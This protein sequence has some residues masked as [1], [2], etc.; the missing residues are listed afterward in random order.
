MLNFGTDD[1]RRIYTLDVSGHLI[2]EELDY[3]NDGIVDKTTSYTVD[4]RGYVTD[5]YIDYTSDGTNDRHIVYTRDVNGKVIKQETDYTNDGSIEQV[6]TYELDALGQQEV[7]YFDNNN[8]GSVDRT[9]Y[10]TRDANGYI[11]KT[12]YDTDGDQIID[13]HTKYVNDA[14]GRV[15]KKNSDADNTGKNISSETYTLNA[16]GFKAVIEM[17]TDGDSA[18]DKTDVN[19]FDSFGNLIKIERDLTNNGLT[20]DDTTIEYTYNTQGYRSSVLIT[21]SLTKTVIAKEEYAYSKDS[22]L[23]KEA[24]IDN[25]ND[26]LYTN[27]LDRRIVKTYDDTWQLIETETTYNGL[28]TLLNT[29]VYER[30]NV[31]IPIRTYRDVNNDGSVQILFYGDAQG[32]NTVSFQDD[33]RTWSSEMLTTY[34][35]LPRIIMSDESASTTLILDKEV[36]KKLQTTSL[37]IQGEK[38]DTVNLA[39]FSQSEKLNASPVSEYGQLFNQ[40]QFTDGSNTYTVLIDTDV[41]VTFGS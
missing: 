3:T 23:I 27:E 39:D 35:G 2:K 41:V 31:G 11:L 6:I 25:T 38:T 29:V 8:D 21:N 16:Y 40:Y 36:V 20:N 28:G 26:G 17:D 33:L 34:K 13:S 32:K 5:E 24:L 22:D 7:A 9:E 14:L 19:T 30:N 10:Y 12:E 4:A 37:L 1:Q 18:I 15:T